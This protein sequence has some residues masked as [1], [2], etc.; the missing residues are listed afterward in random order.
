MIGWTADIGQ[1]TADNEDFRRVVV[2]G[3]HSQLTLMSLHPGEDQGKEIHQGL[4]EFI[5]VRT[6]T[7]LVTIGTNAGE[8]LETHEVGQG[9]GAF[10]PAG[11]YHNIA[12][13]GASELKLYVFSAPPAHRDGAV[14]ESRDDAQAAETY[15]ERA[16]PKA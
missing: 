14:Y 8:I 4:D 1:I 2:T 10:I 15:L 11:Y 12:N 9:W 7:A 13:A 3:R 16:Y 5:H 6:G